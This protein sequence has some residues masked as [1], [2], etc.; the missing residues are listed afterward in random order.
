MTE[1]T[2]D[3]GFTWARAVEELARRQRAAEELGGAGELGGAER[4]ERRHTQGLGAVRERIEKITERFY[5]VG[6]LARFIERDADGKPI[7]DLPSSY[8]CGLGEVAG[9]PVAVG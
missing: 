2:R 4:I 3:E 6:M 5:E 7:E 9:R 8:V 1:A